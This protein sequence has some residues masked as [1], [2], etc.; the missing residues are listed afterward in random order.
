ML[1]LLDSGVNSCQ[2]QTWN[3]CIYDFH[4]KKNTFT[5]CTISFTQEA[6]ADIG[7][8]YRKIQRRKTPTMKYF[9]RGK[10]RD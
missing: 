8:R 6:R 9:K 5:R 10:T 7:K 2:E 1:N 3:A 4:K